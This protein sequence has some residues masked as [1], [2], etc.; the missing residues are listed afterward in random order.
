MSL[1]FRTSIERFRMFACYW[2]ALLVGVAVLGVSSVSQAA[3]GTAPAI[4]SALAP[5]VGWAM[6]GET[7][8]GCPQGGDGAR[9]CVWP[10]N[11]SFQADTSGAQFKMQVWLAAPSLVRLP[12]DA[13]RWP[14]AV[15][16]DGQA[17]TIREHQGHP[18]VRLAAGEHRIS[19]VFKWPALPELLPIPARSGQISLSIDGTPVPRPRL[20][21]QGRLWMNSNA[22]AGDVAESDSIRA[23][24]YRRIQ[25]GVPLTV[26]TRIDLNVSG[27][28]RKIELGRIL[29]DQSRATEIRSDLPVQ[30]DAAGN[31]SVYCRPGTHEI[32]IEAVIAANSTVIQAP[33]HGLDFYDAQEVWIWIPEEVSRSVELS[34]LQLVDPSRTSLPKDWHG[35]RTFLADPGQKLSFQQ[36][37]RGVVEGPNAIELSRKIWLDADGEG[38]SIRD[39]LTGTLARDWRLEYAG[40]AALGHLQNDDESGGVLITKSGETGMRGVEIREAKLDLQADLRQDDFSST[41]PAIGWN[42]DVQQ[43]SAELYL[44]PGWTLFAA[45][46]VDD[47]SGTW[48]DSWTLWDFF[49]VLMVALS[50]G[51][52]LGWRW[53]PVAIFALA[54]SHGH[55]DAPMWLWIHLIATLALLRVLPNGWWRRGVYLWR[56]F[57]LLALFGV[58]ASFVHDQIR[59]GLYPQINRYAFNTGGQSSLF[60]MGMSD[61]SE[62][63]DFGVMKSAQVVREQAAAA[64][65]EADDSPDWVANGESK[66]KLGSYSDYRQLNQVDPKSVVQTGPGLPTWTWNRWSLRWSGPVHKDHQ[67]NLWL[68]SPSVNRGLTVVRS[69]LLILLALLLLR[70]SEMN[71]RKRDDDDVDPPTRKR[72]AR[73]DFWKPLIHVGMVLLSLATVTG[74]QSTAFAQGSPGPQSTTGAREGS[75]TIPGPELLGQ[76]RT[77]LVEA[78][79]C[80]DNCVVVSQMGFVIDKSAVKIEAEVHAQMDAAWQ[81]PGPADILQIESVRLDGRPNQQLR[82]TPEGMTLMRIPAGTHR[83]EVSAELPN[84]NVATIQFNPETRPKFVEFSSSDWTVDGLNAQGTPENSLQ[85]TRT[86]TG[87]SNGG[88]VAAESTTAP[89]WFQVNRRIAL[90][91]P[92]KVYTSV[93]RQNTTRPQMV[94]IPL[95]A[96]EKVISDGFRVEKGEILV[97]FERGVSNLIYVSEL[98]I[99]KQIDLVAPKGQPWTETWMLQCSRIWSCE[100]SGLPPV[101][102]LSD[103]TAGEG[104]ADG[105]APGAIAQPTWKPWPGETLTIL[106]ERPQGADGQSSTVENVEY[107]VTPGQRL[108]EASLR[109]KIRASQG[110]WQTVTLPDGAQLQAA[111]IDGSDQ[112]LRLVDNKVNL[113]LRPGQHDYVLEWQQPWERGFSERVPAVDIGSDA[114]NVNIHIKRGQERWLLWASGPPWGPAVLFW[115]RLAI[116]LIIAFLLSRLRGLPLKTPEWLLL[117]LGLSQLPYVALLPIVGWFVVLKL[118]EKQHIESDLNFNFT[119]LCLVALTVIAA[120]TLYA[121]I[122]VNLLVDI[123]MQVRGAESSNSVLK[124]YVDRSGSTLATPAIFSVPILVWRLLMLAW[125]LW[126][127]SRLLSWIPWGWHAFSR[128]GIWRSGSPDESDDSEISPALRAARASKAARKRRKAAKTESQPGSGASNITSDESTESAKSAHEK[129]DSITQSPREEDGE[130]GSGE[131]EKA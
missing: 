70:F 83:V 49:F 80:D 123:D 46:G 88:K 77:R 111:S 96:G 60:S 33:E 94:S 86:R 79:R 67:M 66:P 21:S 26:M 69:A 32:V 65:V 51:K 10:G 85:W 93:T 8:L 50:I 6:D 45:G 48:V 117:L 116:L 52:L 25:D 38:L 4:P 54:L 73:S 34:G 7:D 31:A 103:R 104:A 98:P 128:D 40:S 87:E 92:W 76:L 12:G 39:H 122:H 19:G 29:L 101:A 110:G 114:V 35:H 113:P 3:Q 43:L 68:V 59:A 121:A 107:V 18:G 90:G 129:G 109:L 5:W 99:Q 24:I 105:T 130:V 84:V 127:V 9:I 102:L 125:A 61:M 81:L 108:M 112:S 72:T 75:P 16:V 1:N 106:V 14:Q 55:A 131:D 58:L 97:N 124:W 17:A 95:I 89:P 74:T 44:P 62:P 11:L 27:K 82:R 63:A 22:G 53:V 13:T 42:H 37:R 91:L 23:S 36:V 41:M 100:P 47:V 71:W 119:Q 30:L 20:D 120:G 115:S 78:S 28:A 57:A 118:K 126:L 15:L 64:P 56:A 2:A